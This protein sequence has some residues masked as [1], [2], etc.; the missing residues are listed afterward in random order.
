MTQLSYIPHQ[1]SVFSYHCVDYDLRNDTV[2]FRR[3]ALRA[4]RERKSLLD[5]TDPKPV[6]S[7]VV[8][9]W[10]DIAF[11]VEAQAVSAVS[12]RRN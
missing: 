2:V 12:A 5:T 8:V 7:I 11:V 3:E 10:M 6:R 1:N 9:G 4:G